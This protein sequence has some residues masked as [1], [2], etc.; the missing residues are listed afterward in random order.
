MTSP[1][2]EEN[3]AAMQNGHSTLPLVLSESDACTL[4]RTIKDVALPSLQ[5]WEYIPDAFLYMREAEKKEFSI[6][7]VLE[8]LSQISQKPLYPP[9]IY[10]LKDI[11]TAGIT[12]MNALLK[13][14]E[15]PPEQSIILLTVSQH[16]LLLPTIA[17]RTIFIS[18]NSDTH[19]PLSWEIRE[20][21]QLYSEKPTLFL[22]LLYSAKFSREETVAIIHIYTEILSKQ[23]KRNEKI[24]E[25]LMEALVTL[26]STNVQPR[27]VLDQIFLLGL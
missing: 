10:I 15:E 19:T 6:K 26:E 17:S 1:L 14:L 3:I 23:N 12:A 8:F 5:D 9:A 24:Y 20:A 16:E 21:L 7:T 13:I 4:V 25:R 11:D 2:L 27:H 18:E 22:S